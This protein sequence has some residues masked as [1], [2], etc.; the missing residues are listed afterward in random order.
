MAAKAGGDRRLRSSGILRRR[1]R[2][3]DSLK[4]APAA[5]PQTRNGVTPCSG[6]IPANQKP[7]SPPKPRLLRPSLPPDRGKRRDVQ[8]G[9]FSLDLGNQHGRTTKQENVFL[10]E[11][12][13]QPSPAFFPPHNFPTTIPLPPPSSPSGQTP[14]REKRGGD[15]LS[16]FYFS[17]PSSPRS[18]SSSFLP[19]LLLLVLYCYHSILCHHPYYLPYST[20][21]AMCSTVLLYRTYCTC[22]A[23]SPY[24]PP[25]P[26]PQKNEHTISPYFTLSYPRSLLLV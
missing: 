18:S 26:P 6:A 22:R 1:R 9:G 5:P 20:T 2:L 14:A 4:R 10:G 12:R 21:T 13:G 25:P 11:G 23:V 3:D 19:V 8:E 16:S 15:P 24:Q 17:A 7:D